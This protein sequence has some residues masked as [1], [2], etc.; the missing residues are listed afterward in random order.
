MKGRGFSSSEIS[1]TD[2]Q[3]LHVLT[4]Y[5]TSFVESTV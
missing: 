4:S 5:M 2:A 3:I 1:G